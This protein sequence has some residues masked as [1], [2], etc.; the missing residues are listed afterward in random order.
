MRMWI[1]SLGL[2]VAAAV[3]ATLGAQQLTD[4]ERAALRAQL[5]EHYDIV[6]LSDGVAL[7]PKMR[8][9]DVRLIEV[10]DTIAINGT[11][12]TGR[13]LRERLGADAD[14][15]LRLSYLEPA[16]R[17]A[18]A[19]GARR[20]SPRQVE[21]PITESTTPQPRRLHRSEG[22]RVRVFGDVTVQEDEE[23]TGQI[24]AVLGSVRIDG[25]V[26]DQI[27]AVLGS[28]DLGPKAVVHGDVV[29]VGGRVRRAEGAQVLGGVTEVSL[30]EANARLRSVP[31][32][33]EIAVLSLFDGFGGV[34]RLL[35]ST[36]R[37]LLLVLLASL[38]LVAARGSVE[39]SA[40]R[41]ADNPL[42]ATLVGLAAE[43]LIVPV[44][45]LT[46]L[47]LVLTFVGIPL[48]LL[49]PFLVLLLIV[50]ALVGFSGTALAIG[51]WARRRFSLSASSGVMDVCVGVVLILLPLLVGRVIALGGWIASPL[52]FLLVGTGIGVEF[53]A[54]SAGFGAVLTNAF[55]SWRARRAMVTPV[56]PPPPAVP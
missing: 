24:V 41:V 52:S 19:L 15:I 47:I 48:L 45:A 23:I 7:T 26:G 11:V 36:F 55:G 18:L 42:K 5:E 12:V 37:L 29:S 4:G 16:A 46:S 2:I 31:W 53:L 25:D 13:E 28:V 43:V 51:Q 33:R 34:P 54:W 8:Q 6:P 22:D 3:T 49:M 10:S 21:R 17:R 14:A 44:L 27:V 32:I 1:A 56:T 40:H 38:A 20:E 30:G 35:A 39:R 9:S 50:M